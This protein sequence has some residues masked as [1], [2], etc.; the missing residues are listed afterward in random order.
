MFQLGINFYSKRPT[1]LGF[2]SFYACTCSRMCV[3]Q[4]THAVFRVLKLHTAVAGAGAGGDINRCFSVGQQVT[5]VY[6]WKAAP[7]P[8]MDANRQNLEPPL[9]PEGD[10][11]LSPVPTGGCPTSPSYLQASTLQ[12]ELQPALAS[13]W[14][15]CSGCSA[16]VTESVGH[17][18]VAQTPPPTPPLLPVH[19]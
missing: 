1:N 19:Q 5:I 2:G 10:H 6:F 8:L 18:A 9:P 17:P 3:G 16:V 15:R 7:P 13:A 12:A 14:G 4:P 11:P